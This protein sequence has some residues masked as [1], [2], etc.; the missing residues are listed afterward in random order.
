[1]RGVCEMKTI[2]ILTH[3]QLDNSP[4]CSFVHNHAKAFVNAGYKVIVLA[5]TPI[6]FSKKYWRMVKNK[7]HGVKNIDGV[8]VHYF[9]RLGFSNFLYKSKINLNGISYYFAIRKKVKKIMKLNDV[10]LI[11]A[12]MFKVEGFVAKKLKK[13]YNIPTFLTLHGTSFERNLH[14]K[15]GIEEI[16]NVASSIDWMICVS[17]KIQRNLMNLGI[18]NTKVIYNGVNQYEFE[19]NNNN[20]NIISVGYFTKSKNFD[21]LIKAF[22]KVIKKIPKARLTIV[23]DGILKDSLI[24]VS[25]EL[26][27]GKYVT[28]TGA[29]DNYEVNKLLSKSNVFVLPSSPEG[30]GIVYVEAMNNG[31]IV[32]GTKNE[33][34]DGF[35]KDGVN[36]FLT[37]VDVNEISDRIIDIFNNKYDDIRNRG[38]SDA[39]ELTWDNN[40]KCYIE[41]LGECGEKE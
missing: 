40:V 24:N 13:I 37:N 28:F 10:C 3:V 5:P 15:N 41:L 1:M 4:Y 16:K 30:F 14:F 21:I 31:C 38:Y 32:I 20:F 2:L 36:G 33:G 17:Q 34:I 35:V 12:H 6:K 9:K 18:I 27:I 39:K 7:S 19:K 23:G 25:D 11:D 22:A 26:G 29:L 8:E